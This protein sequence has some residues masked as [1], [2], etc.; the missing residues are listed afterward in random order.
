M[1]MSKRRM[2]SSSACAFLGAVDQRPA[3]EPVERRERQIGG[4]RLFQQ[5]PFA[6]AIFGQ[7]D[8]AGVHGA[9]RVRPALRRAVEANLAAALAQA[10]QRLE[11]LGAAGPDQAGKAE[12]FARPHGEARSLRE[13]GR[14]EAGDDEGGLAGRRGRARR[15]ERQQVAPDHQTRH[16]DRLQFRGGRGRHMLAVAQ[17]RDDV[18]DRFDLFQTVRDVDDRDALSP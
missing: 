15:I 3:L 12:N 10:E 16:V 8:G 7:I 13:T 6:L 4:H 11:Q 14:A 17:H 18:G 2:A 9:A 5:Q 1:R